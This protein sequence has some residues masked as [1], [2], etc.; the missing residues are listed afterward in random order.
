MNTHTLT[1]GLLLAALAA[2]AV[3]LPGCRGDREDKPPHQFFPDLDDAPKFKPQ[4]RN[5]F[6]PDGRSMR[7]TVANTVAFGRW[8]AAPGAEVQPGDPAMLASLAPERDELLREDDAMYRGVRGTTPDG[9]P[10]YV[11]RIPIPVDE[12]LLARGQERFTIYCSVC[13]GILGRGE[14]MVGQRWTGRTV[15]NFHDPKYSDPKEPDQKGADG[16][17]YHTAMNGVVDPTT[18]AQKMPPYNHALSE[19][20]AWAIVAYIRVLQE[21]QRGSINDVPAERRRQ[22][23]QQLSAMPPAAPA[24]G[25][26][27]AEGTKSEPAA[28]GSAANPPPTQPPQGSPQSQPGATAPAPQGNQP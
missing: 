15:A 14:G 8:D 1:H 26:A 7:P 28:A 23:E 27:N 21:Q 19:R 12:A 22:L 20:D 18:G 3:A 10:L 2:S 17:I 13:H 16:F 11:E 9:K 5:D 24:P 4:T 6:F 25:P